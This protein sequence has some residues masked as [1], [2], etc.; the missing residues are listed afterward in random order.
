KGGAVAVG[1]PAGPS[2]TLSRFLRTLPDILGARDLRAVAQAIAARH[3]EGCR[4]ALGMGAHPIKVGLSP[5]I[6]DLMER[7]IVSAVAMNG[8]CIIHDFELA[9][10]G[11][12]SEDVAAA[13]TTGDIAMAAVTRRCLDH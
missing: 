9:Y 6:I 13:L 10:H 12:T 8:A 4:I 5:L 3:R 2:M 11:A 7:G 1:A